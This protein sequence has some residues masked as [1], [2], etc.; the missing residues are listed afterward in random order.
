MAVSNETSSAATVDE[1]RDL[2]FTRVFD[3]P[4]KLVFKAWTDPTHLAQWWGPHGFTNPVCE[5]DV[6]PGGAIR[7]EMCGPD[8]R[9][10]PMTGVYQEIV[11]PE[12]LVF[13]SAA[14]DEAGNPLFEVLNSIDFA[15]RGGKTIVTLQARVIKSTAGATRYLQG[16]EEGWSQSLERLDDLVPS[17]PDPS[18]REI[19]ATRVFDARRELV[20]KMWTDPKHIAQ[21][22]GPKG[23]TNT[24]HEMDVRPGGVWRFVM[25]GPDGR[26]YQNEI[27]YVDV[28]EPKRLVY[29]HVSGPPFHV[30]A[31]FAE[32]GD[33][34]GVTVR[35]LFESA[36][37][38]EKVAK[39]YGAVEG[40][41]QT[42][43]RLEEE[44]SKM[45]A[46]GSADREFVITRVFDA[47]RDLMWKAWTEPDRLAQ[48]FGPKGVTI[49]HSKNDLRQGGVYHYG[50]RTPDGGEMWGKWVYREIVELERLVFV[51]F[52]S[53]EKRGV[54]RHPLNQTWPLETLSTV[55]FAELEGKTRITVRWI[56]I[57]ATEAERKTFDEAHEGMQKGWTGTF[58]QLVEYLAKV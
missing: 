53:D 20:W 21:W 1:A 33:K 32:Q 3:A 35:M 44:L 12:R 48:W 4:R 19:V 11:E 41:Q 56:A 29:D 39:E 2:T 26:D 38:R 45:S 46:K 34:T 49:V 5:L 30:M 25:H 6:R 14:L 7:V 37:Q 40:L 47:P 18:D 51:V 57:N 52:F 16:M 27:V 8:G 15:D 50:M 10:Y 54:T 43:G 31:T 24:I 17:L 55:T 28:V 13:T 36:T 42:L 23:F 9:V 58:D 22:W